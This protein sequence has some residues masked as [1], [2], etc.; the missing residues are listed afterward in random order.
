MTGDAGW[1]SRG[2]R[3]A[4]PLEPAA[5]AG[6]SETQLRARSPQGP[7]ARAD[8]SSSIKLISL[9]P[10]FPTLLSFRNSKKKNSS[11]N[12]VMAKRMVVMAQLLGACCVLGC[13]V[14]TEFDFLA[15]LCHPGPGVTRTPRQTMR[16]TALFMLTGTGLPSSDRP[17]PRALCT[18]RRA[19][20]AAFAS[21]SAV[22]ADARD[23]RRQEQFVSFDCGQREAPRARV[24]HARTR[25]LQ[26]YQEETARHSGLDPAERQQ[27][28]NQQAYAM[29][30]ER[31]RESKCAGCWM[32]NGM[33]VCDA[34]VSAEGVEFGH[35]CIVYMHLK[36]FT[37][38]S[39]T[40]CLLQAL[41]DA[42]THILVQGVAEHE[43]MLDRLL[44]ASG[45]R[46]LLL[47]PRKCP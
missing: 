32:P 27:M 46:S 36:E 40:G 33:C 37:K 25:R 12:F 3:N 10:S 19:R 5:A 24:Q 1:G 43:A 44:A 8:S 2:R 6:R 22:R 34:S 31:L 30:V 18:G 28:K 13:E 9:Q 16:T 23:A 17:G 35:T 26:N 38:T 7:S 39:N 11:H 29:R 14:C 41:G 21:Q 15:A 47:F 42:R 20:G 4:K 45:N